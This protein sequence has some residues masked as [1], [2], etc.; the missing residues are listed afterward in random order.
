LANR[1]ATAL[2]GLASERAALEQVEGDLGRVERALDENAELS[3]LL[4]SPIVSREE[5]ARVVSAVAER[6]GLSELVGN[7]LGVLAEH[8][9]LAALP[10]IIRGF[11]NKLAEHRGEET[12][13]VI[14]A[15][16]LSEAQLAEVKDGV[17][18]FVGRPV[19]LD[20][21][22]DPS[23]LGGIVVRVGSRMV[24]ASLKSKL[25]QLELSMRGVR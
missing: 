18:G 11:R 3:R 5:H 8:R 24:D 7:F 1:Y 20:S 14:S 12:A 25:Q 21:S 16:P 9:R 15:A 17:A 10:G 2:F 23:L 13:E 6:L 19:N 4:S 22:V